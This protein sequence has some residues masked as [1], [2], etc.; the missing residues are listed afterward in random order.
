MMEIFN[1]RVVQD[2]V[3][4]VMIMINVKLV[5]QI[6][7]YLWINVTDAEFKDVLFVLKI[8]NVLIAMTDTILKI[9]HARNV[10]KTVKNVIETEF[11]NNVRIII[12]CCLL[13]IVFR[14]QVKR[15]KMMKTQYN[16]NQKLL[17]I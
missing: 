13:G 11:V 12:F 3:K 6:Q 16:R 15:N 2:N 8:T 4:P 14:S 9:K 17:K 10:E 7:L 1:V 5:L